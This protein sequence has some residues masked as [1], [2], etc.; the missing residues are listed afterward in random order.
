MVE[1]VVSISVGVTRLLSNVVAAE[2]G[3]EQLACLV[4]LLKLGLPCD[5]VLVLQLI[6]WL[7]GRVICL[8]LDY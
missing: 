2:I 1:Q 8:A 3:L 7:A 5:D 6:G 4:L